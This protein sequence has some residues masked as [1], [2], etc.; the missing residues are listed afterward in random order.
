M[1]TN[2]VEIMKYIENVGQ[3]PHTLYML[4]PQIEEMISEYGQQKYL[5]GYHDREFDFEESFTSYG[6]PEDWD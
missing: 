4:L 2:V 1:N 5:E 3:C 6:K